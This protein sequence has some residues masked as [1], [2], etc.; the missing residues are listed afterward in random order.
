MEF[1]L[2]GDC[3]SYADYY[4]MGVLDISRDGHWLVAVTRPGGGII[5]TFD[6]TSD[7]MT[8]FECLGNNKDLRSLTSGVIP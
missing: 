2:S 3:T 5:L 1:K 8:S 4:P 7:S 6:L